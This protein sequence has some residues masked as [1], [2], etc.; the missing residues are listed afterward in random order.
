MSAV[1]PC[2]C[3]R[4]MTMDVQRR[5]GRRDLKRESHFGSSLCSGNPGSPPY[6]PVV[7]CSAVPFGVGMRVVERGT[8]ARGWGSA[9]FGVSHPRRLT[10]MAI[11]AEFRY[12]ELVADS[13]LEERFSVG[14]VLGP[15]SPAAWIPLASTCHATLPRIVLFVALASVAA[16]S[17]LLLVL[18]FIMQSSSWISSSW[19][20]PCSCSALSQWG[21]CLSR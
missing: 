7:R 14:F 19:S 17:F 16:L 20:S 2:S 3:P 6:V 5:D 8:W 10:P 9:Q 21:P 4:G 18:G 11:M 15:F 1:H 13:I 12:G